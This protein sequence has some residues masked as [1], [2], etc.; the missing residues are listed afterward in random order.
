MDVYRDAT[1]A[2]G[3]RHG[4]QHQVADAFATILG[5]HVTAPDDLDTD[6]FGTFSGEVPRTGSPLDALLAKTSLAAQVT[7]LPLVLASEGSYGP[8]PGLPMV[9]HEEVLLFRDTERGIEVIEGERVPVTL[10]GPVRVSTVDEAAP[11]LDLTGFGAQPRPE[12]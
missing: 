10:P 9:V 5:A 2:F 1:V 11:F 8:L 4:K 12:T 7:G 6:Q 3:T